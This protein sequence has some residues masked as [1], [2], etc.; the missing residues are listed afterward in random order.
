MTR[1]WEWSDTIDLRIAAF[2]AV[3]RYPRMPY[4]LRDRIREEVEL[5]V[6]GRRRLQRAFR[7]LS[8]HGY[9]ARLPE[10]WIRARRTVQDRDLE[11]EA[12]Q[13]HPRGKPR[14]RL[15]QFVLVEDVADTG[16]RS[17]ESARSP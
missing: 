8:D 3:G 2:A 15:R 17:L 16:G 7:W 6:L 1:T 13:S 5:A 9:I 4:Q 10:G 14:G 12:A 11:T